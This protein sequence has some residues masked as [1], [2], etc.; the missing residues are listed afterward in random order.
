MDLIKK[1]G[2]EKAG[3]II[4]YASHSSDSNRQIA[5]AVGKSEFWVRNCIKD[6][7]KYKQNIAD[8]IAGVIAFYIAPKNGVCNLQSSGYKD[9]NKKEIA[10]NIA[11]KIAQNIAVENEVFEKLWK[12]YGRIGSKKLAKQ[13]FMRL[14]DTKKKQLIDSVPYYKAFHDPS[15]YQ[16]L[17]TYI[18]EETWNSIETYEGESIPKDKYRIADADRFIEW[19]NGK[20]QNTGIPQISKLTPARYRMLNI[21]YTLCTDEMLRVMNI[22]LTNKKYIDMADRKMID[23]DYIFKPSN[24]RKICEKGGDE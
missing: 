13:R 17:S 8:V 10:Q 5:K 6:I 16:H 23:F 21:C 12:D 19:F 9:D 18:N 7:E 11:H 3:F 4:Y 14:S 15:Y 20:V 22:L 1:L 2:M 24:L